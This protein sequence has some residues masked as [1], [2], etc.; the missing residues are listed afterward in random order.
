MTESFEANCLIYLCCFSKW[1]LK[2]S[3]L[4]NFLS[5]TGHICIL[6][7][8]ICVTCLT[9]FGRMVYD[10][11]QLLQMKC[12][13]VFFLADFSHRWD[14]YRFLKPLRIIYIYALL[15]DVF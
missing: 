15:F 9:K 2:K 14:R 6:P 7:R 8:C 1:P 4:P 12:L 5:H 13:M 11:S 3:D 10:L